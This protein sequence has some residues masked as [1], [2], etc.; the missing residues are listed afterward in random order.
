M[1]TIGTNVG[2]YSI[3][4]ALVHFLPCYIAATTNS[5]NSTTFTTDIT[6]AVMTMGDITSAD[7]TLYFF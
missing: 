1:P 2:V 6:I 5:A 7:I 3:H 4:I